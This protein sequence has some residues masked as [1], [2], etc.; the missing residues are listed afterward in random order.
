MV[1]CLS[2]DSFLFDNGLQSGVPILLDR[3]LLFD[4]GNASAHRFSNC[5]VE[6]TERT[7]MDKGSL[8]TY[9]WPKSF[10]ETSLSGEEPAS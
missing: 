9:D 5:A 3:F 1:R 4:Q 10:L 6:L 8:A 2:F 7:E